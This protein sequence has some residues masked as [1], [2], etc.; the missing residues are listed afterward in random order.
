LQ[1]YTIGMQNGFNEDTLSGQLKCGFAQYI[2]LEISKGNAR[3]NRAISRYLPWLYTTSSTSS[4]GYFYISYWQT[5][6]RT[7]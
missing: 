3:E 2:A 1:S 4:Q 6:N 7:I 5:N